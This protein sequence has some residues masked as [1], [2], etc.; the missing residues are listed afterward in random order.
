MNVNFIWIGNHLPPKLESNYKL[1]RKLNPQH[2]VRLFNTKELE[3]LANRYGISEVYSQVSFVNKINLAKYLT[4]F[5]Y[6]GVVSDIDIIWEKPIDMLMRHPVNTFYN[7]S[8]WPNHQPI[9]S[10]PDFISCVRPHTFTY[11]GEKVYMFDDHLIYSTST[12]IKKV[13]DCSLKK[14]KTKEYFKSIQF[15]PFGPLSI[16]QLI[17]DGKIRANMWFDKQCQHKG[18]YCNHTHQRLWDPTNTLM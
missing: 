18:W 1:C 10:N 7:N 8:F 6:P 4:L 2:A 15:E 11:K 12:A 13:I 16:T 5:Y 3:S 9:H 14:W 17:Y